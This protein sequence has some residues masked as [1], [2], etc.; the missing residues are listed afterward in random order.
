MRWTGDSMKSLQGIAQRPDCLVDPLILHAGQSAGIE[1][2][3][4]LQTREPILQADLLL[5]TR[6][7]Y[8]LTRP[9][10]RSRMQS[11]ASLR[12]TPGGGKCSKEYF[13]VSNIF[14][15]LAQDVPNAIENP[16]N[17]RFFVLIFFVWNILESSSK[18]KIAET[19]E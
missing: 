7:F 11:A 2:L 13:L 12:R 3:A 1:R 8:R 5:T 14:I 4:L 10:L 16:F 6:T 9:L 17:V 19:L 15:I 18:K